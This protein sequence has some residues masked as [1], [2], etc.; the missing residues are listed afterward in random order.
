MSNNQNKP[1][2]FGISFLDLQKQEKE[3]EQKKKQREQMRKYN[4]K[5]EVREKRNL[6]NQNK[7]MVNE[8]KKLGSVDPHKICKKLGKTL[9]YRV[10][11][12]E[13]FYRCSKCEV[14]FSEKE[15]HHFFKNN[16]CP[17]CHLKLRTR[18]TITQKRKDALEELIKEK[19]EKK[20]LSQIDIDKKNNV[21]LIQKTHPLKKC[22]SCGKLVFSKVD[23]EKVFGLRKM[24]NKTR[25]QSW[26][27]MCR[28]THSK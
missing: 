4:S 11:N 24:G 23:I 3:K 13:Y 12:P 14:S 15:K 7:K 22:P 16:H 17:C 8:F 1:S 6:K 20:Q 19:K 25:P 2:V 26:C 9:A 5:Q 21:S 27:R 10:R 18:K 28:T